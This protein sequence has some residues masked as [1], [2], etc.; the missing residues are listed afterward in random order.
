MS[1]ITLPNGFKIESEASIQLFDYQTTHIQIRNKVNLTRHAF[2][3]LLEGTKE[4]VTDNHLVSIKN[5]EFLIMKSGHCLMSE[6]LTAINQPYRSILLFFTED[7]IET[8]IRKY[9]VNFQKKNRNRSVQVGRY[10]LFIH[11]FVSGL[12]EITH[13]DPLIQNRLLQVKFEEIMLYL[14]DINGPDYFAFLV[15]HNALHE[16]NFIKVVERNTLNKLTLKELAFLSNMSIS[17][18]RRAFEKH[19]KTSPIK[20]FQDKRLEHAAFLLKHKAIRPSEIFEE[21]GYDSLSNFIHAFK[22]KYGVTP[23]QYQIQE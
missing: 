19:Y 2:S 12:K 6:H 14:L 22:K 17:T 8:F 13:L 15:G 18:F 23:K 7:D 16:K 10:D 4:I 3:F 21:S 9:G 5:D 1:I 11:S 20:W